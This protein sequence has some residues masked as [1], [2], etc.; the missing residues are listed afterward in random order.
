[1]AFSQRDDRCRG[2]SERAGRAAAREGVVLL[3]NDNA[4]PRSGLVLLTGATG[5]VGGRL[6]RRLTALGVPLRCLA[7]R[8]ET[9]RARFGPDLEVV[10]GDVADPASLAAALAG[11]EAAYY[12]IHSMGS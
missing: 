2:E 1:M 8:P 5:Y 4:K 11:V 10:K 3:M 6:L 7:R 12:L 9:L